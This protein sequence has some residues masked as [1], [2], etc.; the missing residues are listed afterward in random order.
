M[1]VESGARKFKQHVQKTAQACQENCPITYINFL[2][3]AL[4]VQNLFWNCPER[5]EFFLKLPRTSRI[6]FET[7]PERTEKAVSWKLSKQFWSVFETDLSS[8]M[9]LF[10]RRA[11][12]TA[13]LNAK[14]KFFSVLKII[15][16]V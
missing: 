14:S 6:C 4:N 13:F 9:C 2:E 1:W 7:A 3:T 8:F 5:P 12:K 16:A 10:R 11:E 15:L